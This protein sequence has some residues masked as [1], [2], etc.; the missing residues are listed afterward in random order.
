MNN[1]LIDVHAH[2]VPRE[3]PAHPA[4]D[5]DLR[6]PCMCHGPDH[7]ATVTI[8]DKPFREIDHRS[9][10]CAIRIDDMD[11]ANVTMQAL[12]PMPELLSYWFDPGSGLD[13]CRW[14]NAT[15]AQMVSDHPTRFCG[16]GIL[17]LQD[18]VLATT[19]LSRLKTD[20]FSGIEIGSNIN[21][22]VLG[23]EQ[24]QEFYAEAERLQLAIFVHALHPI[25]TERLTQT[26]DLVPFAAFPLDTAL[27]AMSLIRAGVPE[28]YPNLNIGF[29]HGGGAVIPLAHRLGK[30]ADVTQGFNGVLKKRPVEYA[31]GFFYDNLVYDPG[32]L[33]YL[34]NEFAPGQVFCGTDY[35]YA[36]MD[37]DPSGFIDAAPLTDRQSVRHLAA[38]R[39]LS[40][41]DL[42][43]ELTK[44]S[45]WA[46]YLA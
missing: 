1:R 26:P 17:P 34:A 13:M 28:T 6:W 42:W 4:P 35:P 20:G 2:V 24:F 41:P 39:F 12:S 14:M 45:S 33:A 7:T 16:L 9:W 22:L 25:G 30:G 3:F 15:I 44:E 36:I 23:D 27:A 37:E 5:S 32:Y 8:D 10:D 19:E 38:S 46:T 31:R 18:P 43:D 29:S 21:G 11:E 40:L